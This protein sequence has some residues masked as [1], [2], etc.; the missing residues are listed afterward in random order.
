M[1]GSKIRWRQV[2]Y[3]TVRE[4]KVPLGWKRTRLVRFVEVREMKLP[5]GHWE[6]IDL[7]QSRKKPRCLTCIFEKAERE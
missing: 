5:C 6:R 4:V 3:K 1:S 7:V 2:E